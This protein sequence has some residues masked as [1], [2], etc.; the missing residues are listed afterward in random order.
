[1]SNEWDISEILRWGGALFCAVTLAFLIKSMIQGRRQPYRR[2]RKRE[3]MLTLGLLPLLTLYMTVSSLFHYM[4]NDEFCD[5]CHVMKPF[6]AGLVDQESEGLAAAHAQHA[7]IREHHCYT[8]HTDYDLLGGVRAKVRG[9]RH[10]LAY[11]TSDEKGRPALYDPFPNGNCLSCHGKGTTYWAVEDHV[12]NHDEILT[13]D[14][15]C[16]E[17]HGPSHPEEEYNAYLR[18]QASEGAELVKNDADQESGAGGVV[19]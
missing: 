18:N 16:L 19:E 7:R 9:M 8:C 14:V 1:M 15:S 17:C 10:L 4:K 3:L 5:S 11:Y 13:E 2:Q 6:M 12:D